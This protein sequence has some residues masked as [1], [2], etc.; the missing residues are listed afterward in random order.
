M[1]GLR[2]KNIPCIRCTFPCL[3]IIRCNARTQYTVF[4]VSMVLVVTIAMGMSL[5]FFSMPSLNVFCRQIYIYLALHFRIRLHVFTYN[6]ALTVQGWIALIQSNFI[7]L[8]FECIFFSVVNL[9]FYACCF[10]IFFVR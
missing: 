6:R 10:I 8:F 3:Y 2:Q 5:H 7:S 9:L 1:I 4:I